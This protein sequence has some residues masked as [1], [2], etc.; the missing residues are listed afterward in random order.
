MPD[1]KPADKPP[2]GF[3]PLN[4]LEEDLST[5]PMGLHEIPL[6]ARIDRELA[7]ISSHH[8]RI[9]KAI[10]T[11]WGHHDCDEYLQKLILSGGDGAGKARIGFKPVVLAAL[12]NLSDLHE[13]THR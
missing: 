1:K 2:S 9:G 10:S 11:F 8:D 5:R 13:V 3:P 4:Y 6:Q 7:I 12:F